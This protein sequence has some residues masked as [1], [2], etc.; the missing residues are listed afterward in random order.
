MTPLVWQQLRRLGRPRAGLRE[1][2]PVPGRP[3]LLSVG[4]G[5]LGH[6]GRILVQF[7]APFAAEAIGILLDRLAVSNSSTPGFVELSL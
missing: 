2:R 7:P 3:H 5:V 1:Q 4:Q 6:R